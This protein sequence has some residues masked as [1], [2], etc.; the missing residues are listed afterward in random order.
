MRRTALLLRLLLPV[1]LAC[2]P[3]RAPAQPRPADASPAM[4]PSARA[5]LER[6]LAHY[7][8]REYEAAIDEF[9]AGYEIDPRPEFL[10][11]MAQAERLSGD[12]ASAVILYRRFL[13][14]DPPASHADPARAS[15]ERCEIA[16][17]SRPGTRTGAGERTEISVPRPADD[18]PEPDPAVSTAAAA[19]PS[20][21][22]RPP[23][24]L[25][26]HTAASAPRRW[27]RDPIGMTLWG[28]GAAAAA[29]GAGFFVLAR[30]DRDS[31]AQ[32]PTH[33]LYLDRLAQADL[34]LTMAWVGTGVG[35]ALL[36]GAAGR[37]LWL[38]G[39]RRPALALHVDGS[40]A[41]IGVTG[42]W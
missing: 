31:A 39:D 24:P 21:G 3:A 26:G 5:R 33:H 8:A 34:R 18:A 19:R 1:A 2:W 42:M 14:T 41:A 23:A 37:T 22:S 15:L 20:R 28:L 16:L 27:Y 13:A 35:V 36:G 17:Q 40:K 4:A 7:G 38:A 32:A 25:A 12:C 9:R 30:A 11:A 10:F 6:G 29:G